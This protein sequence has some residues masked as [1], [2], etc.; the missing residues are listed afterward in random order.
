MLTLLA[1]IFSSGPSPQS[2]AWIVTALLLTSQLG[3]EG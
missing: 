1:Q 2:L 3:N